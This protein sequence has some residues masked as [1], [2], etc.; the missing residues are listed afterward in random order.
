[1]RWRRQHSR[2]C[3]A[4]SRCTRRAAPPR[5]Q[6]YLIRNLDTGLEMRVD[7]FE[8]LTSMDEVGDG[9]VMRRGG[10]FNTPLGA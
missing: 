8:R 5:P 7:D 3:W 4:R 2:R 1:M 6:R 9:R 10:N